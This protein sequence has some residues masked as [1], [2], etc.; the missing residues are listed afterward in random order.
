MTIMDQKQNNYLENLTAFTGD[1]F[2]VL[3]R[4]IRDPAMRVAAVERS[5]PVF[6]AVY[7]NHYL[8]YPTAPFQHQPLALAEDPNE[9]FI[10]VEAF[11]GSGKS[12]LISLGYVLWS[13]L[14]FQRKKHILIVSGTMEQVALVM[15]NIR[16][17]LEENDLLKA[18]LG[19]FE[20][21]TGEWRVKSFFIPKYNARVMGISREAFARGARRREHR[22]DVV[23]CDDT[24][25]FELLEARE[26]PT[27]CTGGSRATSSR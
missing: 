18:D 16:I 27:A 3:R 8:E 21:E 14:G 22:P 2:E 4:I 25:N 15:R 23:L 10:V 19:P 20:E 13:I 17:E 5:F 1:D 7:L 26:G 24:E 9:R 6:F 11:R 12:S